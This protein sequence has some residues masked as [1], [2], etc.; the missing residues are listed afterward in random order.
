MRF[1]LKS[2]AAAAALTFAVASASADTVTLTFDFA[3]LTTPFT[4]Y[5]QDGFTVT[6]TGGQF[7]EDLTE[8]NPAGSLLSG[9]SFGFAGSSVTVT[10]GG[11]PFYFDS[12]DL[13]VFNAPAVWDLFATG[14]PSSVI[15]AYTVGLATDSATASNQGV[16]Q[17]EDITGI[18]D[19]FV[20][21]PPL[22]TSIVIGISDETPET[23]FAID[24][25]VVETPPT[26]VTPSVTPEPSSLILLG[27]GLLGAFRAA[28]RR[29]SKS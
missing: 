9:T 28:R 18:T 22:I 25:I 14:A 10:D 29:F 8:G 21:G 23:A 11:N 15:T 7:S 16:W 5:T 1:A 26:T 13:D 3:T 6:Q 27:T 2:F 4:S 17:T 20:G 24:N 19:T 12:F